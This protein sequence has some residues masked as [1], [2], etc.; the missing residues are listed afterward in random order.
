MRNCDY[1]LTNVVLRKLRNE[2]YYFD[3]N[4]IYRC[5][6][7]D[8]INDTVKMNLF[9]I[10]GTTCWDRFANYTLIFGNLNQ[11]SLEEIINNLN[12]GDSIKK[13]YEQLSTVKTI[14]GSERRPQGVERFITKIKKPMFIKEP[15]NYRKN[16]FDFIFIEANIITN[17]EK[18]RMQYIKE[19]KDKIIDMVISKLEKNISFKKYGIPINFLKLSK[20]TVSL[21]YNYIQ[22]VFELKKF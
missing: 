16:S 19:N 15:E 11:R 14:K 22:F 7:I 4:G 3:E 9:N 6:P 18:D 2:V 12:E 8:E 17:W 20:I 1:N 13:F 21:K 5:S 10:F